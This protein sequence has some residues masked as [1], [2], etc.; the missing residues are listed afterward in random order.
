[1][2]HSRTLIAISTVLVLVCQ[3][4][5]GEERGLLETV[6]T[7]LAHARTL[8]QGLPTSYKC[9]KDKDRLVGTNQSAIKQALGGPDYVEFSPSAWSYFFTSPVPPNQLGGSHPELTFYFG[10]KKLVTRVT[11]FYVR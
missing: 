3:S 6:A 7:E 5:L 9:P 11:C 10:K 4:A 8:P 2:N 1:V